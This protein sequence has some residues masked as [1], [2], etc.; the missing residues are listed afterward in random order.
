L[1]DAPLTPSQAQGLR[2]GVWLPL[3]SLPQFLQVT[4]E[5][6]LVTEP[7][8]ATT[9]EHQG[10]WQALL[11]DEERPI[12]ALNWQ[13]NPEHEKTNSRGRSLPLETFAPLAGLPGVRF[14]SLQKGHGSEQLE[15]C[16]FRDRFMNVQAQVDAAWDFLDT[17]AI[18]ACCDLVITSD[19]ALA[20]LAGGMGKTTWLLLK[21]VP[22][23]RWG[24]QGETIFWYPS[25]RLFRQRQRGDWAEVMQRVVSA[26]Q[27]FCAGD[28]WGHA[29]ALARGDGPGLCSPDASG[30]C[31]GVSVPLRAASFAHDAACPAD[32]HGQFAPVPRPPAAPGSPTLSAVFPAL[33]PVP[34]APPG[35][36][37]RPVSALQAPSLALPASAPQRPPLSFASAE[38]LAQAGLDWQ[39]RGELERARQAYGQALQLRPDFPEALSNLGLVLQK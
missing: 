34:A 8:I 33:L 16:S 22:E 17:A 7:Y 25:L 10:R 38:A 27:A 6:P 30:F 29:A 26:L 20:H 11:A 37:A 31:D 3:L 39:E 36:G 2:E 5:H 4:P 14:L 1:D 23:W 19:T 18:I 15:S 13:G 12:I 32:P 28:P 35:A 24:L 21:D 9:E